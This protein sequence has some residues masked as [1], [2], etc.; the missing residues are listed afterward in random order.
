M[1]SSQ[2]GSRRYRPA[3]YAPPSVRVATKLRRSATTP[4]TPQQTP[5]VAWIIAGRVLPMFT[6]NATGVTSIRSTPVPLRLADIAP[7]VGG[8]VVAEN[9]LRGCGEH[10]YREKSIDEH[11]EG[12]DRALG[13]ASQQAREP[14]PGSEASSDIGLQKIRW[15]KALG[16]LI[17]ALCVRHCAVSVVGAHGKGLDR[18]VSATHPIPRAAC[19]SRTT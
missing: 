10:P 9:L 17:V 13:K 18:F 4:G 8:A 19:P 12:P 16:S 15:R 2:R 5:V 11:E 14:K 3:R 7:L 6:R 1:F